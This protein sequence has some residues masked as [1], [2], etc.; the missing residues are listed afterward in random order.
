[1]LR[2]QHRSTSLTE[3]RRICVVFDVRI[4]VAMDVVAVILAVVFVALMLLMIKGIDRI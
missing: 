1:M 2:N 3:W 4:G